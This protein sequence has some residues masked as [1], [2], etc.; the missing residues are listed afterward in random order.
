MFKYFSIF[1]LLTLFGY[2]YDKYQLKQNETDELDK[3]NA[4]KKF[5]LNNNSLLSGKPILWIHNT[6][7]EN[8]RMWPS[9]FSRNTEKLNQPYLELCIESIV[10]KCGN[11]FNICLID[12][13]SFSKLIPDFNIEF[14]RLPKPMKGHMRTLGMCRLLFYYGG[15]ILPN[16]TLVLK[17]L[18]N[19]Y[20]KN[21]ASGKAFTVECVN[22][23][24]TAEYTSF[25]PNIKMMGSQRHN[26]V[27]KS[28]IQSLQAL[29]A[30]DY[31][32]EMDFL[33]E[34]NRL[35]FEKCQSGKM[36]I[37]GGE[38]LG[39]KDINNKPVYIDNLLGNS[40]IQYDEQ[41]LY[42][43]Y[44]PA[45]EILQRTKYEWFAR[46]SPQQVLSSDAIIAKYIL[47]TQSEK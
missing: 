42:G 36:K 15:L 33:G 21:T 47:I 22:R 44:I 16:S 23:T 10:K 9:F 43:I 28:L 6:Y 34:A 24:S 11:S 46:L 41:S 2:L 30:Q 31:T 20:Y 3:Y 38:F 32:S 40:Y 12:D 8:A 35:L 5:L 45:D 29:T 17:D 13:D 1:I 27:I 19:F 26:P 37:V 7:E 39:T 4:M 25:F 14:S 18:S